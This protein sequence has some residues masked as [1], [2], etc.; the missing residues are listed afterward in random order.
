M[1]ESV[2]KHC[3]RRIVLDPTDGWVDPEATGDDSMWREGCDSHDTFT[4]E[5]EPTPESTPE[6]S[7]RV[8]R[9]DEPLSERFPTYD[10][11]FR[12]LLDHQSQSVDWAMRYEGYTIEEL[13]A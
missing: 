13:P 3:G 6:Q 7:Y 2:C 8:Y 11:A 10:G 12:W 1:S 9:D 4:A 5:H